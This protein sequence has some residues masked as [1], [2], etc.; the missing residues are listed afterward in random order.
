MCTAFWHCSKHC[1]LIHLHN[2][3]CYEGLK[4]SVLAPILQVQ[5][6][7]HTVVK[8][9][10]RVNEIVRGRA[11]IKNRSCLTLV[12]T[13]WA[14]NHM[15]LKDLLG[16]SQTLRTLSLLNFWLRIWITCS[17]NLAHFHSP[18][19]FGLLWFPKS[20]LGVCAV[21][22]CAQYFPQWWHCSTTVPGLVSPDPVISAG[23][24]S[25]GTPCSPSLL[26]HHFLTCFSVVFGI[27]NQWMFLFLKKWKV[28]IINV[29]L[30]NRGWS[31]YSWWCKNFWTWGL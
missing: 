8:S 27:F 18:P 21:H 4:T 16:G 3:W 14:A 11:Q 1:R 31:R 19:G 22:V 7:R 30:S 28:V 9:M 29:L 12:S 20:R 10:P 6:Q 17:L 15:P 24:A 26:W 2:N 13:L 25:H 23:V 5:K